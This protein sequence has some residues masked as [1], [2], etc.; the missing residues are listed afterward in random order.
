MSDKLPK[1]PGFTII[2]DSYIS[3]GNRHSQMGNYS[4]AL[5]AYDRAVRL[6]PNYARAYNYS[7]PKSFSK[8]N[9][10]DEF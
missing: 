9:C 3:I 4:S 6:A 7:N 5:A 1:Q 8:N 2:P 10:I